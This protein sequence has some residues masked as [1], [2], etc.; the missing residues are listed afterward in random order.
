MS[1]FNAE[2]LDTF[3]YDICLDFIES[4][5]AAGWAHSQLLVLGFDELTDSTAAAM[6]RLTTHFG[7]PVLVDSPE[8]PH[9]NSHNSAAKVVSIAC[10][11]RAARCDVRA[12]QRAALRQAR[13]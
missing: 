6:Q 12:L 8:L 2:Q 1:A 10:T 5:V 9:S 7:A 3:V 4:F 13:R 11:T